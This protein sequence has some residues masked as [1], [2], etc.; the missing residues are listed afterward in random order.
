MDVVLGQAGFEYYYLYCQI[1]ALQL[2]LCGTHMVM[3][4][5]IT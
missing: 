5:K 2:H 1:V 3:M 4:T